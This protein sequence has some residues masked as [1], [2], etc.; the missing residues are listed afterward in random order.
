MKREIQIDA[1]WLE[2][3][4]A[5]LGFIMLA[6]AI[7]AGVYEFIARPIE[8]KAVGGGSIF[9][10]ILWTFWFLFFPNVLFRLV[11]ASFA[12]AFAMRALA[13]FALRTPEAMRMAA[14]GSS[15]LRIIGVLCILIGL[16]HEAR[17]RIRFVETPHNA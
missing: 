9:F 16:L 5:L 1:D 15:V 11:C 10:G 12:L 13:Q 4:L 3:I 14:I 8:F 17:K 6:G 7:F 2:S